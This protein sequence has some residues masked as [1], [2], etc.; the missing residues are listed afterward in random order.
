MGLSASQVRLLTLTSRQ[1]SLEYNAQRLQ[2]EKLRL[3]NESDK[4]YNEYLERLDATKV[5]YK[6]VND[7]GSIRYEDATF[8]LMSDAGFMFDVDGVLCKNFSEVVNAL[9]TQKGI[10]IDSSLDNSYATLSTLISEGY[11]VVVQATDNPE[12]GYSFDGANIVYTHPGTGAQTTYHPPT[13]S[14][15]NGFYTVEGD[16]TEHDID[17]TESYDFYF[18]KLYEKTSLSSSTK[19][20]EVSDEINLKKA[21]AQYEAD[22]NRINSKDARYDNE[23]SQLETERNAIKQEI[24]TLKNVAKENVDRTFKIFS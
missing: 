16:S 2:A 21:E 7:N 4:V 11:V 19:I 13:S 24:D 20:Q 18:Y 1:H 8:N 12:S 23:L 5:Q 22:M 10:T 9:Q 3:A 17:P 6:V 14:H 15:P